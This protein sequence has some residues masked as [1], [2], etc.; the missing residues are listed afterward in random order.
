M[1]NA[2]YRFKENLLTVLLTNRKCFSEREADF[3]I[4]RLTILT[5]RLTYIYCVFD[6]FPMGICTEDQNKEKRSHGKAF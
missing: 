5:V 4:V 6:Y 1:L 3:L 2:F